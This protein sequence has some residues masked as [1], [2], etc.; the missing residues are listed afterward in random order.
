MSQKRSRNLRRERIENLFAE[1]EHDS[2]SFPS[3]RSDVPLGW[4]WECDPDKNYSY[5]SPEVERVLGIRVQ[6]FLGQPLLHFGLTSTSKEKIISA[7]ES[8]N[9]PIELDL[10]YLTSS[11]HD[12]PVHIHILQSKKRTNGSLKESWRGFT[13]VAQRSGNDKSIHPVSPTTL[14]DD[15]R[16][17]PERHADL[18]LDTL[19]FG[20]LAGNGDERKGQQKEP[21]LSQTRELLTQIGQD[22]LQQGKTIFKD[23]KN[24]EPAVMALP[25]QY[26]NGEANLLIEMLDENHQRTWTDYERQLI[27][28]VANQLSLALEN[29]HLFQRTQSALTE[30]E[31]RARELAA[32]NEMS[33]AFAANLDIESVIQN[34]YTYTSQLMDTENFYVAIYHTEADKIS[35]HH[36]VADYQLVDG[37]H[38]EWDFWG[39]DQSLEG[40]TGHVIR[41]RQPLLVTE[42]ARQQFEAQ[43]LDYI[44]VGKG[45]VESWLGVPMLV[46][47]QTIGVISVQSENRAQLYQQHHQE[48]LSTIGHQAAIAIVN[49]R[50]LEETRQRSEDLAAL[51]AVIRA[52]SRTL[53]LNQSLDEILEQ[54]LSLLDFKSGLITTLNPLSTKLELRVQKNLPETFVA[55]L[56]Q[57]GLNDTLCEL[58]F[59]KGD[60]IRIEDLSSGAPVDVSGLLKI[61]IYAY[62]GVP[63]ISKGKVLG[64]VCVFN[65]YPQLVPDSDM[66]LIQAIGQQVGVAVENAGLFEQA[67]RSL[68][69][70]ENLYQV[71][72]RISSAQNYRDILAALS[73]HTILGKADS[74]LTIDVFDYP[75]TKEQKPNSI[76]ILARRFPVDTNILESQYELK[77]FVLAPN[78]LQPDKATTVS[79]VKTDP[80]LDD[81]VREILLGKFNAHSTIFVPL[82]VAG[83]WVGY[84][85]GIYKF[86]I[87][88]PA[89]EIRQLMNIVGQ[90]A[91]AIQTIR[92]LEESRR[93]ADQLQTAADIARDTSSTLALET[94]LDRAVTL[95]CQGFN[96]YHASVFLLD[97]SERYAVVHASTGEAGH[98]MIRRGHKLA[99]GS[100]SIVGYVTQAG[101]PLVV[102]DVRIDPIH[103]PNPL[104]PHT[105][106]E[107]GIPLKIGDQV[108]GAFD[109]QST[110]F[111]AFKS[112]DISVLQTLADQIAVAVDNARSYEIS[113]QAM[114]EMRKADQLK[115]Q[116][117]ANMSHELRTP[118]NSIIGFSRVI[119]KGI[120]GPINDTQTQDLEAI[121][122][123]GQH[124]LNLINDILDLS[125]IEAGKMELAFENN[126]K[127]NDLIESVMPTV[128]GLVKDKPIEIHRQIDPQLPT[129]QADPI[130]I[131]QILINL[132]SNAAKF[133]EEGSITIKAGKQIDSQNRPEILIQVIDTGQGIAQEDQAKLFQP[134]SQV[135][136][137]PTRKTGGSGLGL[138]ISR[139]LIEMHGGLIGIESELGK[140]SKFY[141]TLPVLVSDSSLATEPIMRILLVIDPEK[142]ITGLYERYLSDLGYQVYGVTDPSKAFETVRITQPSAVC[143]EVNMPDDIGWQILRDLKENPETEH[144]PVIIC[145]VLQ[146]QE[147]GLNMRANDY[148]LKPILKED[149]IQALERLY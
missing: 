29:A 79:D 19:P 59:N 137:S 111:N 17:L 144:I 15:P 53:D 149:L 13:R 12:I 125:K 78:Y 28:Q 84:I 107:L 73:D 34:I 108:I 85:N 76:Q 4:T 47:E 21:S 113:L 112:E 68:T 61:G 55:Y 134:F 121:Y 99:V 117:L 115:S 62:L 135:D 44:Q 27:E 130:K 92:L 142:E 23:S 132:L 50:L 70:T 31:M 102:N 18:I 110:Q 72:T 45:G 77:K 66:A 16:N 127:I 2:I 35:F 89:S 86:T 67:Q 96:Y 14:R 63:L 37:S 10:E 60:T 24:G 25:V 118:L 69:E 1:L 56:N 6:Q 93:K 116:F 94:L 48:L 122:H 22:S 80:R 7:I 82:V 105:R 139:H 64:T 38:P 88:F 124:L 40:L 101:E 36:V 147:Q 126:I 74:N 51:N 103:K 148:L 143:L 9:F 87:D 30:S 8:G 106:A 128:T 95:I 52:A 97:E 65:D 104:L 42:K 54:I 136:A 39:S 33:R 20:I 32:L 133:T 100:K 57:Y 90:A 83:Q 26:S 43:G 49:A 119:L 146:E 71:S 3:D 141:F 81:H 114:E 5:C 41:T 123:S 109:V 91:V 131:R 138:S 46:G 75:W 145:S 11:G 120:D 129:V 98:E 140:G 58:V